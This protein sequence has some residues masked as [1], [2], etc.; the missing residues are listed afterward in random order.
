[1]DTSLGCGYVG[2]MNGMNTRI[3]GTEGL[4]VSAIG[5][6]CMG[7]SQGYG[8]TRRAARLTENAGG[9]AIVLSS[10]D[11]D[12]LETAVPRAAWSGDRQSFAA[13]RTVRT[14]A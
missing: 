13:H 2:V 3:L 9:A 7:M 4:T 14:S 1:M 6:N 8:G 12:R 10:A 11:L 5:L